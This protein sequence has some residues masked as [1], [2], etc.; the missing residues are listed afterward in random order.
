MSNGEYNIRKE[1]SPRDTSRRE[2][3]S[4]A[5]ATSSVLLD[6]NQKKICCEQSDNGTFD[7]A[8]LKN[9]YKRFCTRLIHAIGRLNRFACEDVEGE[10]ERR[11]LQIAHD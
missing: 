5:I 1:N 7:G 3:A 2:Q 8:N 11:C 6:S 4:G 10:I 9:D